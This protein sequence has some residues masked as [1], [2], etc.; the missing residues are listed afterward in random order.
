MSLWK[1]FQELSL[2][3]AKS[4]T[5]QP[6]KHFLLNF[7]FYMLPLLGPGHSHILGYIPGLIVILFAIALYI[8]WGGNCAIQSCTLSMTVI[9]VGT[10]WWYI[11]IPT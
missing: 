1:L 5:T 2:W 9:E 4:T 6:D 10:V 11:N 7:F 8:P 3:K